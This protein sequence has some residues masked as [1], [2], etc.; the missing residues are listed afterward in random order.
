MKVYI[1]TQG[2]Y[3]DYHICAV[4]VDREK[5]ER[6]AKLYSCGR[7]DIAEVEEFD[8]DD[9]GFDKYD[10]DNE[11]LVRYGVELKKDRKP[12]VYEEYLKASDTM[13]HKTEGN[14][15]YNFVD[16]MPNTNVYYAHVVAD[17][18][19]KAIKIAQD[20]YAK[21]LAEYYDL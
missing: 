6:I 7:Y 2:V 9:V 1:I 3:S 4:A 5:A 11:P 20:M 21:A 16:K 13:K 17:T 15:A 8:T 10:L 12:E 14:F 18:K 19:E